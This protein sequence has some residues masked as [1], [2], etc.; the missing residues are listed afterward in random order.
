MKSFVV[1][2]RITVGSDAFKNYLNEIGKIKLLSDRDYAIILDN[3][4]SDNEV[5]VNKAKELLIKNSLRFVISVA[6]QYMMGSHDINDLVSEGNIGLL[7]AADKYDP[8]TGI[9]FLSYAVWWVRKY[10]LIFINTSKSIKIPLHTY[11]AMS[12]IKNFKINF[13]AKYSREPEIED[14]YIAGF[15]RSE[16]IFSIDSANLEVVSIDEMSPMNESDSTPKDS[17]VGDD[18]NYTEDY[19]E[20]E[21]STYKA[22]Q[23]LN[24][25]SDRDKEIMAC[26]F[27][28][29]RKELS[30]EEIAMN[31]NIS[32]ERVR[33]IKEESLRVLKTHKEFICA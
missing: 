9:R 19:E 4:K 28:I 29:G 2:E 5:I 15:K 12:K 21:S 7:K 33:Q 30:M 20:K 22:T 27:G 16:Y 23:L 24:V 31:F 32:R 14:Y 13:M 11:D 25:L 1:K 6:K 18:F 17:I 8:D 10:I 26:L 3:L